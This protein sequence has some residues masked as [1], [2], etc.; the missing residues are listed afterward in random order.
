MTS[1]NAGEVVLSDSSM[2]IK[3][4]LSTASLVE[5][6]KRKRCQF[7]RKHHGGGIIQIYDSELRATQ[8]GPADGQVKIFVRDFQLLGSTGSQVFGRPSKAHES[9]RV[10]NLLR[11][12]F[13]LLGLQPGNLV[14]EQADEK[15]EN[16]HRV[17]IRG[18]SPESLR[19][20]PVSED[21]H[22]QA[23]LSTQRQLERSTKSNGDVQ[24]NGAV[25]LS[26]PQVAT[27]KDDSEC[28]DEKV[29][30]QLKVSDA[31]VR[32]LHRLLG[33]ARSKDQSSK[34][35]QA[36]RSTEGASR[37]S[38]RGGKPNNI[39]LREEECNLQNQ[40]PEPPKT[41]PHDIPNVDEA[42]T[43]PDSRSSLFF[44]SFEVC[45]QVMF[46]YSD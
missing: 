1:E 15:A 20:A 31:Q 17:D 36:L 8:L 28:Q 6:A 5:F 23:P 22:P 29:V 24:V 45:S 33:E 27:R 4:K 46:S 42:L 18:R 32:S 9:A 7:S 41:M 43:L 19:S 38:T 12:V 2:T 35:R 25:N 30:A 21:F 16:Q 14:D 39:D 13:K 34:S 10:Q 11:R 37:A 40:P 44:E 26:G 3:A